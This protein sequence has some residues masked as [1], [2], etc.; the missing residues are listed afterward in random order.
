[1]TERTWF[2][3]LFPLLRYAQTSLQRFYD[4]LLL[5]TLLDAPLLA[6]LSV[7]ARRPSFETFLHAYALVSSRCFT[8]DTYH[9]I[10]LVPLADVYV[11]F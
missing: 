6:A 3:A 2:N 11:R 7:E 8:I 1:V 5:P 4:K 10:A 9:Q